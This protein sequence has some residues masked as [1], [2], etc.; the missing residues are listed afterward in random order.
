MPGLWTYEREAWRLGHRLVA[1]VD[2]AGRGPLA[3]PVV[4]AA[5]ILPSDF[6][7]HGVKDSK[8]LNA[9]EREHAFKRILLEAHAVG[10]GMVGP[11][12]I[13]KIN[14]LQATRLA[15][16]VAVEDLVIRPDVCLL[17][18]PPVPHFPC[19]QKAII[20]GDRL[21]VSIAAASIAAK[22]T[23]DRLMAELD[24]RYPG[25]GFAKH[26]GYATVEHLEALTKLGICPEH[27]KS[28]RPCA[29]EQSEP[30]LVLDP[31]AL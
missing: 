27:R 8:L 14:I 6:D 23:R 18:G 12:I 13:D 19:F 10:I 11:D 17:D 5:V 22:V 1:G 21:S 7:P 29:S 28:F 31:N 4:A 2:E 24:I 30:C 26:K 3:G 20:K 15:M 25:Y 16:A 9:E